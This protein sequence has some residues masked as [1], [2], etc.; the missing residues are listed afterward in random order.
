MGALIAALG[1]LA[2]DL[3]KIFGIDLLRGILEVVIQHLGKAKDRIKS[4]RGKR[5][6]KR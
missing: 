1:G 3:L 6:G 2:L 4:T 5:G